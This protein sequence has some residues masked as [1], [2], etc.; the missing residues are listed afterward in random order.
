MI[1]LDT[2]VLIRVFIDDDPTQVAEARHLV[3]TAT[4]GQ[5]FVSIIVFVEFLWT[6]QSHFRVDK[7]DLV[8]A[9]EG[10]LTT[11]VFVIEDRDDIEAAL[12][13]FKSETLD[14]PDCLIAL[15][16]KRFGATKTVSFDRRAIRSGLFDP[17]SP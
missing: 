8:R 15:R 10:L 16:H 1:G 4:A 13:R 9:T 3:A 5:L 7:V 17:L 11:S 12:Q 2:N 14:F 6:L